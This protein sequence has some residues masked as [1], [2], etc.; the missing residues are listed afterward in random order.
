M[1]K[2]KRRTRRKTRKTRR[3]TR[4]KKGGAQF[5]NKSAFDCNLLKQKLSALEL[6]KITFGKGKGNQCVITIKNKDKE[7]RLIKKINTFFAN[8]SKM[9]KKSKKKVVPVDHGSPLPTDS[10]LVRNKSGK[11][12]GNL[13]VP[14][15]KSSGSNSSTGSNAP[16]RTSDDALEKKLEE[17]Y[18]ISEK[19]K[20]AV[21]KERRKQR[22]AAATEEWEKRQKRGDSAQVYD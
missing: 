13:V 21:K 2:T 19:N 8:I 20:I 9:K 22:A 15:R 18:K 1:R 6:D 3:R 16:K 14:K 11:L 17:I 5:S 12:S 4:M 10:R 7:T